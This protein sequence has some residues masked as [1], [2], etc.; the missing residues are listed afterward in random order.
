[1]LIPGR[2]IR[3]AHMCDILHK[4]YGVSDVAVAYESCMLSAWQVEALLCAYDNHSMTERSSDSNIKCTYYSHRSRKEISVDGV[5][6]HSG[7]ASFG[8]IAVIS[9]TPQMDF[10]FLDAVNERRRLLDRIVYT[11]VKSHASDVIAYEQQLRARLKLLKGGYM[12]NKWLESI[13]HSLA[14]HAI[15][16]TLHR[17]ITTDLLNHVMPLIPVAFAQPVVKV[18]GKIE[19]VCSDLHLSFLKAVDEVGLCSNME[20]MYKALYCATT[21]FMCELLQLDAQ[22][23]A[24][25]DDT[26]CKIQQNFALSRNK[27]AITGQSHYGAHRSD[28]VL[29]HVEKNMHARACS[30]GEQKSMIVALVLAQILAV[31]GQK[32]A[33]ITILLLDD[34]LQHLDKKRCIT[35]MECIAELPVQTWITGTSFDVCNDVVRDSIIYN[36]DEY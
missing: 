17:L 8:K 7:S 14:V 1:M 35:L 2:G 27:D 34:I 12:D 13:E 19:D 22:F 25:Y 21:K 3:C 30:T 11:F 6:H 31:L 5:V 33:K 29:Y 23:A 32:D 28:L 16:I 15:N 36:L 26:L 20:M 4:P 10:I 18:N 24:M 9:L